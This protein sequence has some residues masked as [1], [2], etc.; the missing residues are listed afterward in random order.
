VHAVIGPNGA[1]KTT[2]IN[3]ITGQLQPDSG[4]VLVRGADVTPLSVAA[5]ARLGLARTFQITSVMAGMSV[6]ENVELAIL[7][8]VRQSYRLWP[9]RQLREDVAGAAGR[10]LDQVGLRRRGRLAAGVLSHGER[11][12]LELAMALAQEP[13]LLLLDE[14][15]AGTGREETERLTALLA[16][17][18]GRIPMLLVEHDMGAVFS[19]ADRI[20]VLV[21]GAIIASGTPDE[22][23][24]DP[25]VRTAYLGETVA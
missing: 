11:R 9:N 17:F 5:R 16:G 6:Q 23:R 3:Q 20:S 10:A 8:Q 14:P 12:A 15:M 4:R 25:A 7:A 2:L 1:G 22:I 19:I 18:K 13:A 21:E 24:R